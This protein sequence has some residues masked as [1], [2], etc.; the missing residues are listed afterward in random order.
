MPEPKHPLKV[1]LCH[2]KADKQTVRELY[3]YLKKRGIKPWFDEVDLVGGQNWRVE[4]PEA[5]K[6]SDAIIIC[7]TQNSV[8]REGYVQ[9]EIKFALDRA[10]EMP[11]GRIFIIPVRL[12]V[13]EVPV[14]LKD[15]QWVDLFD[16]SGFIRLMKSLRTR[17]AQ[18]ERATVQVPKPGENTPDLNSALNPEIL[19]DETPGENNIVTQTPVEQSLENKQNVLIQRS[20]R[21]WTVLSLVTLMILASTLC[22]FGI[23][24]SLVT[25]LLS[26]AHTPV[27]SATFDPTF[28]SAYISFTPTQNQSPHPITSTPT[29]TLQPTFTFTS[30][31]LPTTQV[32]PTPTR[33]ITAQSGVTPSPTATSTPRPPTRTPLSPTLTYTATDIII[34]PT[35]TFTPTTTSTATATLPPPSSAD[36]VFIMDSFPAPGLSAEGITWD[37]ENLWITDNSATVFKM[38]SLGNLLDSF[39][40]PEPTPKGLTWDGS[41]L[42]IF[43]TNRS[44]IYQV[45]HSGGQ[46]QVI[47]Y[48]ESP[49]EVLGG[50]I[51]QDM[52]WEGNNLWYAN[53]FKV[54][55]L[56]TAGN[57]LSH[58]VYSKNVMGLDW[59][60]SNL[61]LAYTDYSGDSTLAKVDTVGSGLLPTYPVP[62]YEINGLAWANGDLWAL[63]INTPGGAPMIYK[64]DV[65]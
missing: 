11:E 15:Y 26:P 62:I 10:L 19:K 8:D 33:T 29:K 39:Q 49:A 1:F 32:S 41:S 31:A 58:F 43:T 30:S 46:A 2:A 37:G 6:S 23:G 17:A 22:L 42:W 47:S 51:T 5:I 14:S 4:I 65:P 57:E 28:T 36:E 44:R 52:A 60:G 27:F 18:L 25:K 61:W 20:R 53:S 45:Q 59:D 56:D 40:S 50:G 64:L 34:S 35:F 38:D 13:C 48:F 21:S 55:H 3:H 7:L 16:K 12:E 63:G 24:T 9:S 54:Y